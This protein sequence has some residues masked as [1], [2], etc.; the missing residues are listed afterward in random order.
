MRIGQYGGWV[1]DE[2][3]NDGADGEGAEKVWYGPACARTQIY[4]LL[5]HTVSKVTS[6]A[7]VACT[8]EVVLLTDDGRNSVANNPEVTD[9]RS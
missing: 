1:Q 2:M 9:T 5:K 7:G 3:K 4:F 8:L 6:R